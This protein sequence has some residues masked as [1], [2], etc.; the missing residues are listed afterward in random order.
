MTTRG[1]VYFVVTEYGIAV[2]H[3]R[4][5]RDRAQALL[6]VAAP[7][8]REELARRARALYGFSLKV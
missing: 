6:N 5:V 1:D 8:F 3:G 2:L 4:S 7:W